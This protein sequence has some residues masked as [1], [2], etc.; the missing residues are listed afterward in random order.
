MVFF[1]Y[2]RHIMLKVRFMRVRIIPRIPANAQWR[3][4][5]RRHRCCAFALSS[6]DGDAAVVDGLHRVEHLGHLACGHDSAAQLL[7]K[8]KIV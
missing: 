6:G 8:I 2:L 7:A 5:P 1:P 3:R 4:S